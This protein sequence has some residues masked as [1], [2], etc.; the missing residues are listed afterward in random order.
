MAM[1]QGPG[2]VDGRSENRDLALEFV[3]R[4]CSG[5]VRGLEPLLAPNFNFQGPLFEFESREEYLEALA[6][7]PPE[8]GPCRILSLTES[9][10][11]ASVFYE[12]QRMEGTILVAQLFRFASGKICESLLVF[13]TSNLP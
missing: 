3:R 1:V 9:Q 6:Q 4:F 2:R 8:A 7:D 10:D 12:I 13:D 11:Q 5:E